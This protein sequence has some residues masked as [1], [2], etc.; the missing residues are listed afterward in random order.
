M[1]LV[2]LGSMTVTI[3]AGAF[4]Q[5]G[6]SEQRFSERSQGGVQAFYLAESGLDQGLTWLRG[7]LVPPQGTAR[8]VLPGGWRAVGQ[9]GVY[10]TAIDPDDNN[11]TSQIKRYTIEAWGASGSQATPTA[12][13]QH[14]MIVQ[15]ESFAQYA[16]FT[17]SE[18]SWPNGLQVYFITGDRL[19]G[20][21]HTN[22]QFSMYGR[23]VFQGPV[24]SVDRSINYW[25]G[26]QVTQPVFSEPPKLGVP[27]KRYP[28]SFP[29]SVS[30]AA[31]AGGTVLQGDTAVTLMPDGKMR[32]T[33]TRAGYQNRVMALPG[34]G[35]LYVEGGSVSLE[36]TLKGQ[37]TLG[38]SGDV[39]VTNSVTYAD[40]PRSNP[41]STDVLGIVAGQNVT[42][43]RE[44][45]ANVQIDGT[46][47]AINRSFGVENWWERPP[48]GTLTVNGGIIQANRGV[49]GSF[50]GSNGT[51]LSGYTK[52]YHYDQR[53]RSMNPPFFPTTGDY[54]TLVWDE[55]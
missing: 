48:K 30:D 44:A 29:T 9:Q 8:F 49:V 31:R 2:L 50:N 35:V 16:Y 22:G 12:L 45:P 38:A 10:L 7:Q 36:G 46:I 13:R 39:R 6:L 53:L 42:V 33:N 19:E 18:R 17:N 4:V 20:P 1:L 5:M 34:N 27:P 43:A 54:R 11:P 51:K 23:P 40:D 26:N 21:T 52:D 37:L 55:D 24:S 25:G 14:R 28:T 32:V 15:T 41:N 3:L 47:M